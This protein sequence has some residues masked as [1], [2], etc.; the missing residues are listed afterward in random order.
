MVINVKSRRLSL[1]G[2]GRGLPPPISPCSPVSPPF[3][4]MIWYF[5][6]VYLATLVNKDSQASVDSVLEKPSKA[7]LESRKGNLPKLAFL[8]FNFAYFFQRKQP[9]AIQ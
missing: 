5:H 7:G 2:K 8:V 1:P 6:G 3:S 9:F 4:L